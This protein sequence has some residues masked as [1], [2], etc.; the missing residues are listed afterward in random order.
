LLPRFKHLRSP[1]IAAILTASLAGGRPCLA[2]AVGPNAIAVELA[3]PTAGATLRGG[4]IAALR[5]AETTALPAGEEIEE[6][7]AFLSFDGGTSF[8][9]RI[10]PHLDIERRT[11]LFEV[12]NVPTPDARLL[13][14]FGN[15]HEEHELLLPQSF[16]I[17]HGADPVWT[18]RRFGVG[19]PARQGGPGVVRWSEGDRAGRGWRAVEAAPLD[20]GLAGA[21]APHVSANTHDE[22]CEDTAGPASLAPPAAGRLEPAPQSPPRSASTL[23]PPAVGDILLLIQR[24]NE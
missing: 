5:W 14:R 2:H 13:L 23:P 24:R 9:E 7:E 17:E 12:P 15:E 20:A 6:W 16:R 3:E 10:T 18:A 11:V 21:R 4:E 22:S 8:P 19:E 1:L